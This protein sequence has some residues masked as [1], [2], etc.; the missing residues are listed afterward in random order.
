MN[1]QLQREQAL[2]IEQSFI[3]QAPAGSGKTELLA[4]R[5]LKLLGY[6]QHPEEIIAITFT[7]KAVDELKKRIFDALEIIIEPQEAH[8]KIT[9]ELAQKVRNRSEEL[10][11]QLLKNPTRLKI[12]TLD[13]LAG[14][15]AK[16][17]EKV[18]T[19][20]EPVSDWKIK[21]IYTEAISEVLN[22]IDEPEYQLNIINVLKH[23]GNDTNKFIALMMAMLQKRD[24]WL[25][26]L[27]NEQKLNKIVLNKVLDEIVDNY[28]F[29]LKQ[30][31]ADIFDDDFYLDVGLEFTQKNLDFYLKL[32]EKCLTKS[33]T[34]RK[35]LLKKYPKL[36][37]EN[38]IRQGLNDLMTLPNNNYSEHEW[39]ILKNITQVL[40][41]TLAQLNIVF[42]KYQVCDYIAINLEANNALGAMDEPS[43]IALFLDNKIN[44]ILLDEFQDTSITQ[45]NLLKKLLEGWQINDG[46]T[47]FLVGDP[48][49]SIYKFREAEVGLFGQIAQN[50]IANIKPKLLKLSTNFRSTK[51]IVTANNKFFKQIFPETQNSELGQISYSPSTVNNDIQDFKAVE[52]Y[53]FAQNETLNQAK[54]VIEVIKKIP[55]DEDIA[56]LVRA[57][58]HLNEIIDCLTLEKIEFEAVKF[59][60]LNDYWL[61]RD[62]LS[63]TSA[64]I[65]PNDKLSWLS[66][67]RSPWC[68]LSLDDLLL[69]SKDLKEETFFYAL[70]NKKNLL[71]TVGQE[72]LDFFLKAISPIFNKRG[73]FLLSDLLISCC[74]R[75]LMND[76]LTELEQEIKYLFLKTLISLENNLD[77]S[78]TQLQNS[79]TNLYTP[80]K[81]AR[82]KLMTIHNAKGL[83]F[84]NV[85]LA[86]LNKTPPPNKPEILLV[87]ENVAQKFVVAPSRGSY[88][89][90]EN[91]IYKYIKFVNTQKEQ[92]E[93]MRLLY[94]A[95]TRAKKKIILLS[96]AN[97]NQQ[98]QCFK[99]KKNTFLSFL[100]PFFVDKFASLNPE[101]EE[102]EAKIIELKQNRIKQKALKNA[103]NINNELM[104]FEANEESEQRNIG[105]L[106]HRYFE[107]EQNPSEE[108][109]QFDL[110]NM[111]HTSVENSANHIKQMLEN[112]K[113]DKAGQWIFKQRD[114]TQTEVPFSFIE[115]KITKIIIDRLFIED[116][117]LWIIDFKTTAQGELPLEAFKKIMLKKHQKQL[118][119]YETVLKNIYQSPIKKALYLPSMPLLLEI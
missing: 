105:I 5:Y 60:A 69:V 87:L 103:P 79:L 56:I 80:S 48:M 97:F 98:E 51:A 52:F 83:E 38:A 16:Q 47:L 11:W 109:I 41:L 8:K 10:N 39:K 116:N 30:T 24:Q 78:I 82:I 114:S 44:H 25:R 4:Q 110:L 9:F 68:G 72:R 21:E 76:F 59:Q 89:K 86:N 101:I 95:M 96:T 34:W 58:S 45:V 88:N 67:L 14:K 36:E 31:I 40:K 29:K 77:F 37:D 62:L 91:Q 92:F 112:T 108:K 6:C 3:V 113:N 33:G 107:F 15:I 65:N 115:N 53:A 54:K 70:E 85:I 111:G 13:S 17:Q 42:N 19:N 12:L 102:V 119:N 32:K 61:V 99:A 35:N 73:S 75:L 55:K 66:L 106:T 63:L 94:V 43:N 20:F 50:G 57:R 90:E 100:M 74:E 26:Q 118:D 22:L 93:L 64:I 23:L 27:L 18:T 1:D 71:S 84:D 49:Q 104:L 46:K 117:T 81:Q 7:K 28:L 2:D